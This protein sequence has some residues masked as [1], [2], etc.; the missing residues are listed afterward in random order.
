MPLEYVWGRGWIRRTEVATVEVGDVRAG[1]TTLSNLFW[2]GNGVAVVD[3]LPCERAEEEFVA[4][5]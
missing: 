1:E 3:A 2:D 5:E 4:E